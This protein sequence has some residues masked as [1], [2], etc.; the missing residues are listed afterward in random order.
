MPRPWLTFDLTAAV[1]RARFTD[2]DPAGNYIPGAPDAV[3]SA[4]VTVD[5]VDGW[6]GACAGATSGR[7]RWSRTTPCGRNRTSLW[8]GRIG[9][10]FTPKIRAW[11]DVFNL[12]N[13]QAHDIDYY[14]VSR[15]PGEPAAGVADLHF[16]PVESRALRFSVSF[17][18]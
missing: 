7:G 5:N 9:Y 6:F 11:L 3:A 10:S 4:G 2:D 13:S 17:A 1:T 12:F 15:L 8:N 16:H 14:Y 18:Y